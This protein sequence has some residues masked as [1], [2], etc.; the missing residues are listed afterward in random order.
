MIH[1]IDN[2]TDEVLGF[3]SEDK[4]LEATH[5]QDADSKTE[6]LDFMVLIEGSGVEGLT[7]R[8]RAIFKDDDGTF[9]EVIIENIEDTNGERMIY[10]NASY[11]EDLDNAKPVPPSGK[12]QYTTKQWAGYAL[13]NTG[14]EPGIIEYDGFRSISWTSYNT[15]YEL[16]TIIANH[17]GMSLRFRI[18][19]E[20]NRVVGRYVDLV[21]INHLFNGK[22]IV[23]GKDLDVFKRFINTEEMAT[24]L[25]CLG[26]EPADEEDQ[27]IEAF[28]YDD[29]ANEKWSKPGKYLWKIYESQSDDQNMTLDRLRTLGR[30]ELNKRKEPKIDYEITAVNLG[31]LY[32]HEKVRIYDKVRIKDEELNRYAEANTKR[33]TR[34]LLDETDRVFVFG[35]IIEFSREDLR[36]EFK[37]ITNLLRERLKN[38]ESNADQIRIDLENQ[39]TEY[40]RK[41]EKSDT[42]PTEPQEGDF[43]LDTSNEKVSVFYRYENGQWVKSSASEASDIGAITREQALYQ[44]LTNTFESIAVRHAELQNEVDRVLSSQYLVDTTLETTVSDKLSTVNAIFSD[45]D[46]RL[47]GMT[48]DTATIGEL[49]D[50]Q[51]RVVDYRNAVQTLSI[52]LKDAQKSIEDRLS[53]L[54]SQYSDEKFDEALN[55]IATKFN[56]TVDNGMLMGDVVL[57]SDL[58]GVRSDLQGKIDSAETRLGNVESDV[59]AAER[60]ITTAEADISAA[61]GRLTTAESDISS[62]QTTIDEH[63]T[64]ITNHGTRITN[65]EGELTS[66]ASQTEVDALEGTVTDHETR[67]TQ[68]AT[69]ITS[70]ADKSVVD[71]LSGTVTDHE[72]RITQNATVITSKASQTEVDTITGTVS[73]HET[74]ISQNATDITSKASQSEVDTISGTVSDHESRITQN[75]T[76]ISSRVTQEEF[77]GL[78]IGGRNLFSARKFVTDNSYYY[79]VSENGS[80]VI[81]STDG[82]GDSGYRKIAD[83]KPE[84]RYVLHF[85]L[86][87]NDRFDIMDEEGSVLDVTKHWSD[88]RQSVRFT[89]NSSSKEIRGKFY[90]YTGYD[91]EYPVTVEVQIEEGDKKTSWS[92]SDEDRDVQ[93]DEIGEALTSHETSITQNAEAI[94]S[95]ADKSVVDTISGT[96]SDH[97]TTISQHADQIAS[98]AEQTEVDTISGQVSNHETRITQNATDITSKASQSELDSVSGTV[99]DHETRITQNATDIISKASQSEVDG[100]SGTVSDHTSTL[101]QH[102][103]E[104]ASKVSQSEY[105]TDQSGVI[106]RLNTADSERSQMSDQISDRVTI[107]EFEENT[108]GLEGRNLVIRDGEIEDSYIGSSGEITTGRTGSSTMS[109]DIPVSPGEK[110]TFSKTSSHSDNY[111]RWR[112]H[113]SE[114][115]YIDRA[116]HNGNEFRW[117]VPSNAHFI[118]VS[119]P[120]ASDVKIERGTRRTSYTQSPEDISASLY[121]HET[122]ITQN[123]EEIALRATKTDMN[124]ADETLSQVISELL[125]DST[126]GL[127][128]TYNSDGTLTGYSV[129]AG[130]IRFKTPLFVINDGDVEISDGMT[131]LKNA[132]IEDGHI[133][134]LTFDVLNGGQAT[135]G[136]PDNGNGRLVVRDASGDGDGIIADFNSESGGVSKLSVERLIVDDIQNDEILKKK[137]I[138]LTLYIRGSQYGSDDND[139]LTYDTG[140]ASFQKAREMLPDYINGNVEW[141]VRGTYDLEED[142]EISGLNGTGS[143][144]IVGIQNDDTEWETNLK[145]HLE[146]KNNFL[147]LTIDK[148]RVQGGID[149][150][151]VLFVSNSYVDISDVYMNGA[152]NT[153]TGLRVERGGKVTWHTGEVTNV[154]RGVWVEDAGSSANLEFVGGRASIYGLVAYIGGRITGRGESIAGDSSNVIEGRGGIA[155]TGDMTFPSV[156]APAPEETTTTHKKIYEPFDS[157]HT[158]NGVWQTNSSWQK[159]YPKQGNAWNNSTYFEG[160]WFFGNQFDELNGKTIKRI[161][162]YMHRASEHGNSGRV[163]IYLKMA[164]NSY[165]SSGSPTLGSSVKAIPLAWSEGGWFDV[166]STFKDVITGTAWDSF[167]IESPNSDSYYAM[168]SKAFKVEVTYED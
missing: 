82:T 49:I 18:E 83:L 24:A 150:G 10:A 116:P 65:V 159:G 97:S 8:N 149:S 125:I 80:L 76:E 161:R 136:G 152:S 57:E 20:Y 124:S 153:T 41:I 95:K 132:V 56:L 7:E 73:N 105:D 94:T 101:S 129:G 52:S 13:E 98:K 54:Q 113:D 30:T 160:M 141:R 69:D 32:G 3:I 81:K 156:T 31:H 70:K 72:T 127:A 164:G 39:L 40:E 128:Y 135:F 28:L 79:E 137:D 100:I 68:N 23:R 86:A 96:V 46:I 1:L 74:R 122:E 50:V 151:N 71:S 15:P 33:I 104:I 84:Q 115:R 62:A 38:A 36:A 111:W 75:A 93:F 120:T 14:W 88:D 130:G 34:N 17:F 167:G 119:Y 53:L 99:S 106:S 64:S 142:I 108:A 47:D 147:P 42:A 45:I 35:D 139:G 92:P 22:E 27:R 145:V 44:T 131:R 102:A 109:Q 155:H 144:R 19:V 77:D 2:R 118:R 29:E 78:E 126:N 146:I 9:R 21:K 163:N 133:K 4:L 123:G 157:N 37:N 168:M 51:A 114:G 91:T 143:L 138:D 107:T 140:L 61:E 117:T 103:T 89:T 66:K 5:V 59:T 25:W 67:I 11:L 26:P 55:G 162:V 58:E 112:W 90:P 121:Q 16:L 110:L 134:N 6:T 166:T 48:A 165:E 148:M 60:R 85:N 12:D 63:G 87:M 43:W 158:A 154:T